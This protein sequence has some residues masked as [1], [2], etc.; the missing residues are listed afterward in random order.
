MKNKYYKV[1]AERA[2][3]GR[4]NTAPITF[5]Y[6]AA[7]AFEAMEK[8]KSQGGIKRTRL[9]LNVSEVSEEEYKAN[10]G[11]SAYVRAG[12]KGST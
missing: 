10:I 3:L 1:I 9:P 7:N 5:Y 8:S 2:H 12:V 6:K 4:G 11:V